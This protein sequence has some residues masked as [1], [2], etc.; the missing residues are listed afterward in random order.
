LK[1]GTTI[2]YHTLFVTNM[3]NN[4]YENNTKK[5]WTT[6]RTNWLVELVILANRYSNLIE[7][8]PYS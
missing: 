3:L 6:R 7:Y 5:W 8:N 1:T 4:E 2:P